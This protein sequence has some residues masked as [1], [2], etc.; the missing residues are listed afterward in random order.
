MIAEHEPGLRRDDLFRVDARLATRRLRRSAIFHQFL[1]V[2][3]ELARF[4]SGERSLLES[5]SNHV[6]ARPDSAEQRRSDMFSDKADG[7]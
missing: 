4:G 3:I 2:R 1:Q 6:A 5:I 7:G